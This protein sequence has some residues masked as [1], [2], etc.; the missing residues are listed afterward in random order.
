MTRVTFMDTL[1]RDVTKINERL[2][3]ITRDITVL[4]DRTTKSE[5]NIDIRVA[6][7]KRLE[8]MILHNRDT[9]DRHHKNI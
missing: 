2:D 5:Q 9:I 3:V 1:N 7:S 4:G 8:G 6:E